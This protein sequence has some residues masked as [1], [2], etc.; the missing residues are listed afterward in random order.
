MAWQI[1]RRG[2]EKEGVEGRCLISWPTNGEDI[3]SDAG[4]VFVGEKQAFGWRI[5]NQD[6]DVLIGYFC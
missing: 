3:H 5:R 6:L 1:E 4:D 2:G